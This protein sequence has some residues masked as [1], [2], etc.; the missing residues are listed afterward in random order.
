MDYPENAKG[1]KLNPDGND[2][3]CINQGKIGKK[4]TVHKD[5][6]KNKANGAYFV[7]HLNHLNKPIIYYEVSPIKVILPG[8]QQSNK[9]GIIVGV[10]FGVLAFIGII[11]L[12]VYLIKKKKRNAELNENVEKILPTSEVVELGDGRKNK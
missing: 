9:A 5:H 12:I 7:Y 1:M 11:I 4:C 10:I 3:E 6:F 8:G 2:L